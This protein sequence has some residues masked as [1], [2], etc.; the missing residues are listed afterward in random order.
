[1]WE[2]PFVLELQAEVMRK[3]RV[4][5]TLRALKIALEARFGALPDDLVRRIDAVQN[6][7]RAEE[8]ILFAATVSRLEDFPW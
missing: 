6:E 2:S 4:E 1:M 8:L 3:V 5:A 7:K